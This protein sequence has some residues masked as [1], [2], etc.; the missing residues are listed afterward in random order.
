MKRLA[1]AMFA[2]AFVSALASFAFA[3]ECIVE[4]GADALKRALDKAKSNNCVTDSATY[5]NR[6]DEH[7]PGGTEFNVVRWNDSS[8]ITIDSSVSVIENEGDRPLVLIAGPDA[9]VKLK[10]GIV[11]KGSRII[12]D[13]LTIE[14]SSGNG[15]KMLGDRNL[16][17]GSRIVSNGQ[18]GILV[19]GKDNR[20]VDSEI[21]SNDI[22]GILIGGEAAGQSCGG[23][24]RS[25]AGKSTLVKGCDIHDNGAAVSGETCADAASPNSI[26]QCWSLKL[27]TEKCSDLL[28]EDPPCDE[29]VVPLDDSCGRYWNSRNRC[30]DLWAGADIDAGATDEDVLSK[31]YDA[32]AGAQGGFGVLVDAYD[33]KIKSGKIYNNHSKAIYVNTLPPAA[34]CQDASSVFDLSLMQ[35][36]L[37][38]EAIVD[39]LAVSRFP[40]PSITQIA[41]TPGSD[42]VSVTGNVILPDEPWH[43]WNDH[44]V[45]V[46]A[47]RAEVFV[48]DGGET[49]FAGSSP[50]DSSGRF[51][52]NVSGAGQASTFVATLVDTE[53]G[54][55]SP[56]ATGSGSASPTG[57]DDEDGLPNAQE[58]GTDPINPDSDGDGLLDGEEKLH[59]GRVGALLNENY[60]FADL[61]RLDPINPDS[62]GDCLPDGLE[63]GI[64]QEEA[65]A[66]VA[67]MPSKPH[68]SISAQCRSILSDHTITVPTNSVLYNATLPASYENIAMLY[69]EDPLTVSD[70]T[71][72]DTDSDGV[73]DGNEDFNFNGK[74]DDSA[75][76]NPTSSDS[77]SDGIIDGEEGDK[78]NDG[79][80]NPDES[81]PHSDDTDGDGVKDG[82]EKRLGTYP[83]AC[84]SDDD[85]LSDGVEA[86]AIRPASMGGSCHGLEAA[87]TNYKNSHVLNPLN[88]DSDADGLMDG[89]EDGNAN[90]WIEA[91]ESDPSV[92]DTDR[93]DLDDGVEAKG[94]F[95][96]DGVPDFDLRIIT[97]GPKCSPPEDIGD[98]DCDGIPNAIDV[99]SD[100]DG[101]PDFQE[102]WV[103]LNMNSLPD[104]YD[105]EAKSCDQDSGGG[106]FGNFGGGGDS[107]ASESPE[108]Q[109]GQVFDAPW[110]LTDRTG[111]GGCSIAANGPPQFYTTIILLLCVCLLVG[112]RRFS[113]GG[114]YGKVDNRVFIVS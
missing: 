95:D 58:T 83:N 14:G 32:Y 53:R 4:G 17:T 113:G 24:S 96:G 33:V 80:L 74:S 82:Q 86:G 92:P 30:G 41:A 100:D 16:V 37:V 70:P 110:W 44:T 54:N 50:I 98:I 35:T 5:R 114:G 75:E 36:A 25:D 94:D 10:G 93:D 60:L 48:K 107:Q 38:S 106:S 112:F 15:I 42:G 11:L 19:T 64:S 7:F 103:D 49:S 62:D 59:N 104:V 12:V 69:D 89:I 65:A 105:N 61:S 72:V 6:Y 13:H 23:V 73:R 91:M 22:N 47:L 39:N 46:S 57:D 111:G 87:G 84:D 90:G 101:C 68:L 63:L 79:K 31:V 28:K 21:S 67:R 43:P 55:T 71:S 20:I 3:G 34:I 88:P 56:V 45:N 51:A 27:E 85:G 29:P 97:A 26:G 81:D 102:G 66:L 1:T 109:G 99:D 76:S 78:D 77:D 40:L 52:V 108:T 9:T 8:E 2:T 18:N